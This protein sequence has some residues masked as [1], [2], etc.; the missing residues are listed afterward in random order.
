MKRISRTVKQFLINTFDG[1]GAEGA[2]KI[3]KNAKLGTRQSPSK[4]N[5]KE[6][7][8]LFESM[9]HVSVG[10]SQSMQILRLRQ[11]RPTPIQDG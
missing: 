10:D 6:R 5:A 1:L 2:D 3:I 7:G 11:P 4:L 8:A 9:Q